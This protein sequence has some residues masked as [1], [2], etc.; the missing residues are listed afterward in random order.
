MPTARARSSAAVALSHGT[1][2]NDHGL[3][4]NQPQIMTDAGYAVFLG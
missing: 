1:V 4:F 2:G 3:L